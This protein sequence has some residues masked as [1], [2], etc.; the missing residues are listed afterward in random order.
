MVRLLCDDPDVIGT[1]FYLMDYVGGRIFRDLAMPECSP[2][3]RAQVYSAMAKAAAALHRIDWRARGLADFGKESG[4]LFRQIKTWTKQ[5]L[6]TQVEP[7]A[8]MDHLITWLPEHLP[9][10]DVAT[11]THGDFRLDNLIFDATE[12]RV[13]AIIDWELAT[14]GHPLADLAYNCTS[15]YVAYQKGGPSGLLGL[16]LSAL[17]IPDES[18]YLRIYSDAANLPLIPDWNYYLA[19]SMF[20]SAAI[21]QGVYA[22]A[23][24]GTASAPDALRVGQFASTLANIAWERAQNSR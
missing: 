7:I 11:I 13:I 6:A 9:K 3:E 17:G 4:Y 23:L 21:L 1:P 5:Y 12:P 15:Y 24:Q 19:F 14:L 2:A 20:R 10:D 8:A 18:E 16:D 22:R